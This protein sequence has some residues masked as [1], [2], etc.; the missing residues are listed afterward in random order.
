MTRLATFI[1]ILA[2]FSMACPECS[3]AVKDFDGGAADGGT[4]LAG[5]NWNDAI[6][7][8]DNTVPGPADRALI[9]AGFVVSYNTAAATTLGSLIVG[10]DWP[11]TGDLG[12]PGTLN[13]SAGKFTVTGGGD[14]FQIGRACCGGDGALNMSGTA[15]LEIGGSD[16][17]VGTRDNGLLDVGGSA[18]V[19]PTQGVENYWRLGNFG[20]SFDVS[21]TAPTG[22]QGNGL[23]NVHD[24]G[25]FRAHVIFIGD[26]D[27]TGEL[28]V[29]DNGSVI[30]T[31]NLVPRPSGLQ[32]AGSA[33]VR[34]SGSAATLEALNLESES[35]PGEIRTKY[36]FDADGGGV[37]AI[38]L[39][40]AINITNNDLEVNLGSFVFAPGSNITLFDGDQSLAT[41]RIF[42]AFASYTV[43]GV[44]NPPSYSVVYDQAIGDIQLLRIP[45]PSTA[46]LVACGM[47]AAAS[48]K[49]R[50]VP[51][52]A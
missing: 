9:N 16:P 41:N 5:A 2:V 3:A 33:T 14:N 20:P 42:G 18:S 30:L 4:F 11:T 23:L 24:N 52:T 15:E 32:T 13:M 50:I 39:I 21:P 6:G 17:I 43:D 19:H 35:L 46:L 48:M 29:A 28:R 47:L 27:A 31:G 49:R 7:G 8:D 10:A 22:L 45:E 1:G 40:D 44:L 36:R 26:N 37:S 51:A 38:K 34:M 25:S 12:T